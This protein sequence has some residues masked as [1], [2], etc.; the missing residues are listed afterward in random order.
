MHTSEYVT[1]QI[2]TDTINDALCAA[3]G[4][5]RA[6]QAT[7]T[8]DMRSMRLVWLSRLF[9]SASFSSMSFSAR[10]QRPCTNY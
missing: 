1:L 4:L 5:A 7:R 8:Q 10:N 9:N 3:R 6:K 2:A